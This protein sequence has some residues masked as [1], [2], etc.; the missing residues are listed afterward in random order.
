MVRTRQFVVALALLVAGA[1]ALHARKNDSKNWI[2]GNFSKWSLKD[3]HALLEK[4]PWAETKGFRGEQ[5]GPNRAAVIGGGVGSVSAASSGAQVSVT[6]TS[7]SPTLGET[8]GTDVPDFEFKVVFFSAL[9]VREAYVRMFQIEN[10]YDSMSPAKQQAFNRLPEVH[11]L[12]HR[13]VRKEVTVDL[14]YSAHDPIEERDMSQWFDTQTTDTLKQNAYLYA[15]RTQVQLLK[16]IPPS[17]S[18]G[19]GAQFIFPRQ[20]SGEPILSSPGGKLRFEMTHVPGPNQR[21]SFD[22]KPKNMVY[23]GNL[24]Y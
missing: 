13:D 21:L 1:G 7:P 6:R 2:E 11:A 9:P 16:Y 5:H 19:M 14:T 10:H 12:L 22:F 23:N 3:A 15:N 8:N 4:S 18:H 24:S 20:V 17:Q